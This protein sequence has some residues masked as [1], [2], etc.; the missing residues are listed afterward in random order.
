VNVDGVSL[1]VKRFKRPTLANCIIYTLFRKNKAVRAWDNA[2]LFL[3]KGLETAH[4]VAYIVKKKNGFFHTAY[5]ISEYLPYPTIDKVLANCKTE[6]E[7]RLLEAD[8]VHYTA[9]LHQMGIVHRDY[10]EGNILVHKE[11]DGFHFALVDINRLWLNK[12]PSLKRYMHSIGMLDM[13][14]KRMG[15]I[16]SQY[17]ELQNY[18]PEECV[19]YLLLSRHMHSMQSKIKHAFKNCLG[20]KSYRLKPSFS[21]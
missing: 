13:D 9:H 7:R 19:Y 1:V 16:L 12:R 5:F 20:I 2:N 4:P 8:F 15:F 21:S 3:E 10:N 14:V 6:D 17:A 11:S 18:D